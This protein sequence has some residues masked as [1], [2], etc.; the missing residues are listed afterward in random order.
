MADKDYMD[1]APENDDLQDLPSSD[2]KAP[3][4]EEKE[5]FA[6]AA[7][8]FVEIFTITLCIVLFLTT[9]LTRHT[10][11]EG[12]SMENTLKGGQHLLISDLFYTPKKGDI[13][14]LQSKDIGIDTPIVK[15]IVALGG[16]RVRIQNGMV[17]V[18]EMPLYEPYVLR[19][20]HMGEMLN[21]DEVVVREGFAFVLGDHRDRSMDSRYFGQI[22]TRSI[23]GRAYFSIYPFNTFG[24]V[25]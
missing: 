5:S 8:Y 16:D 25:D 3:E 20:C 12:S 13:V 2:Q 10:V 7:H 23:L 1:P 11:V 18:N 14:V 24:I 4:K 15:R 22:D 9:F 21:M 19:G 6:S 17:Y